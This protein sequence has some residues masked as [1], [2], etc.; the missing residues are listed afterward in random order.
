MFLIYY[1]Y[2]IEFIKVNIIFKKSNGLLN[3]ICN[4]KEN[5]TQRIA[6]SAFSFANRVGITYAN[7]NKKTGNKDDKTPKT[8]SKCIQMNYD[9]EDA[10]IEQG[11]ITQSDTN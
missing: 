1:Y 10:L 11:A 5:Y 2:N 9:D 6:N 7:L 4:L 3:F 8:S